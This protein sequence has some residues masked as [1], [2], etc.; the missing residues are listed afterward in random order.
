M[1]QPPTPPPDPKAPD[2]LALVMQA[3]MGNPLVAAIVGGGIAALWYI[4]RAS[5]RNGKPEEVYTEAELSAALARI[6]QKRVSSSPEVQHLVEELKK[7][8]ERL[9]RLLP[10]EPPKSDS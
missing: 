7:M 4:G 1:Q 6:K 8:N 9:D 3:I 2:L 5:R 10:V